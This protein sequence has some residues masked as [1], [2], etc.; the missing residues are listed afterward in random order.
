MDESLTELAHDI[1]RL[2]RLAYP[3]ALLEVGDRLAR[4]CFIDSLNDSEIELV[5]ISVKTHVG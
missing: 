1:K 5:N 2:N 4:D 3:T